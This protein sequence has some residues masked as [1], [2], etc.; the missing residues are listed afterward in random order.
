MKENKSKKWEEKNKLKD[1]KMDKFKFFST[2]FFYHK[3]VLPLTQNNGWG[4]TSPWHAT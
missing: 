4:S 1:K 3:G 2:L